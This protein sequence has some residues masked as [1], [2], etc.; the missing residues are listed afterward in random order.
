VMGAKGRG[1]VLRGM[2]EGRVRVRL[3]VKVTVKIVG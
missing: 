2:V 1:E 3:G